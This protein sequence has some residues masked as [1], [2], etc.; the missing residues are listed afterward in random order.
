[1]LKITDIKSGLW[2]VLPFL[3]ACLF[4]HWFENQADI[5]FH[6]MNESI[7]KPI[8]NLKI[9][10]RDLTKVNSSE[11]NKFTSPV[12]VE[13]NPKEDEIYRNATKD[14]GSPCGSGGTR[15]TLAD[16]LDIIAKQQPAVIVIDKYFKYDACD[17]GDFGTKRLIEIMRQQSQDIRIPIVVGR[18]ASW[19]TENSLSFPILQPSVKFKEK[20]E[21]GITEGIVNL[22][23]NNRKMPLKWKVQPDENK[24]PD[25]LP[26]LSLA[27]LNAF[28]EALSKDPKKIPID[29][30]KLRMK[31][32][33]LNTQDKN[34]YIRFIEP[35]NQKNETIK[36]GQLLSLCIDCIDL[37]YKIVIIGESDD[38]YDVHDSVVN[39]KIPGFIL[40][41]NYIEA[42]LNK[43]DFESIYGLDYFIGFCIFFAVYYYDYEKN[44]WWESLMAMALIFGV[45]YLIIKTFAWYLHIFINPITI[46]SLGLVII[47]LHLLLPKRQSHQKLI[48]KENQ[49]E[50]K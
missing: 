18:V 33:E 43:K 47:I 15:N 36:A 7:D 1:M 16:L 35:E 10:Y 48:E 9:F 50:I 20:E 14:L 23:P 42:I 8:F 32:G 19:K 44:K 25:E 29:K 38:L 6:H 39:T 21:D 5:L 12:L 11:E 49:G 24:A 26:A 27:A 40:Q 45:P 31:L 46:S 30:D 22:D 17:E 3:F 2:V 34:P 13:I 4:A 37:K 28:Y 41:A